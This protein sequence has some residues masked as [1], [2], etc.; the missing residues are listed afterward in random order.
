MSNIDNEYVICSCCKT[1]VPV[2]K[3]CPECGSPLSKV[4]TDTSFQN[5]EVENNSPTPGFV[6]HIIVPPNNQV[7]IE[8]KNENIEENKPADDSILTLVG[9][10]CKRTMATVGGDGYDEIVLY[11]N[12]AD[13][14]FQ[15]HTYTKYEYM[16]K[17][18]HHS[19]KAKQGAYDALLRLVEKLHLNEYEGKTGFGLCGGMYICK[20]KKDGVIHRVTT[21]NCGTDGPSIIIQV[22]NLISSFKGEEI[23]LK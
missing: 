7:R 3:F 13:G 14:S 5:Q 16:Q 12:E 15:I 18:I 22:G 6:D 20:Y 17:E 1:K 2:G 21:D 8:D 19:Y 4:S 10:F 9:D 23:Y 11:E